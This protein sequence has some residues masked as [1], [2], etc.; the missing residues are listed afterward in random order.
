ME[1]KLA[2]GKTGLEVTL[3]DDVIVDIIE[4]RYVEA[5]KDPVE[6]LCDAI[7]NPVGTKPLKE[8]ILPT[9]TVG[10]VFSDITRPTPND[11]ILPV[12][13]EELSFLPAGNIMLFNATGTHRS[14]TDAELQGMLGDDIVK[15]YRI[16]QNDADDKG[17]HEFIGTTKSGNKIRIHKKFL[18]C[19]KKILTGFIEPHFFAG[20][21]GGPKACMPGLAQSETIFRNHNAINMDSANATWGKT[22]GNPVWDEALEAAKMAE[23]TFIVNVSLNRDKKITGVFAGELEKA[24][25]GGTAFVKENAM[26]PAEEPYDIVITSNSGYPLDLNLYQSVKGMSAAAQI[27]KKGRSIIAAAECR[28]P[29]PEQGGFSQLLSNA[30][31]SE[32]LLA[33]VRSKGFFMQDMWQAQILALILQKADV[34]FYSGNLSDQQIIDAF[35]RPCHDIGE[36]VRMLVRKHGAATRICVLPEGP[37]TI[38]Y[39]KTKKTSK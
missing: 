32:E 31:S 8:L 3:P 26:V 4:P 23:P 11:V 39:L 37:Q 19:D 13:L 10:I 5:V 15:N 38:A 35:L 33:K 28:D 27:V 34:Y 9:D 22:Y 29:M 24:H 30:D 14:S 25:A 1:I 16:I 12:I 2:Y 17:S 21:S 20:F 36:T 18:N 6:A 7:R